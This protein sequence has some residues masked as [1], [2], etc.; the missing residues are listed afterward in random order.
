MNICAK[1]ILP[2]TAAKYGLLYRTSHYK[3]NCLLFFAVSFRAYS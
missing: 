1:V 3:A 2:K